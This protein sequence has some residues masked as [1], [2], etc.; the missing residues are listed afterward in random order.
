MLG[1]TANYNNS[2]SN[3]NKRVLATRHDTKRPVDITMRAREMPM[4]IL[5]EGGAELHSLCKTG[6]TNRSR[7]CS[8]RRSRHGSCSCSNSRR[9]HCCLPRHITKA[10][11][12]ATCFPAQL[13]QTELPQPLLLCN[14]PCSLRSPL[15]S[16]ALQS[17]QVDS[18]K[19]IKIE[20]W[21]N[22]LCWPS[23]LQINQPRPAQST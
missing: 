1:N 12:L 2:N 11:L 21:L 6:G 23:K 18:V 17:G 20:R 8:R 10:C 16:S 3:N 4:G 5:F 9:Y 15:L 22:L 14:S 7:S 13:A 19:G